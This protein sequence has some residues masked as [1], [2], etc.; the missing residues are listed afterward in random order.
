MISG[1]G[2]SVFETDESYITVGTGFAEHEYI[3][4]KFGSEAVNPE[5][6]TLYYTDFIPFERKV[7]IVNG[8]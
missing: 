3:N 1:G 5:R 6:F 4:G 2:Y 7:T 8:D